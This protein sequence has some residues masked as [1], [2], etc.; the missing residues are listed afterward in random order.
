MINLLDQY[1]LEFRESSANLSAGRRAGHAGV[2][3]E[4]LRGPH[5]ALYFDGVRGRRRRS[6]HDSAKLVRGP[7]LPIHGLR[8]LPSVAS[9]GAAVK[10]SL[11]SES[12]RKFEKQT[13]RE[14]E[15]KKLSAAILRSG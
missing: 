13:S 15:S 3:K 8:Q 6:L 14:N 7:F 2:C 11:F 9:D 12:R 1:L 5:D 10:E 4:Q